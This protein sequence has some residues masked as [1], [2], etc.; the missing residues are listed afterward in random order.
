MH[1]HDAQERERL[2]RD[3]IARMKER[4][5]RTTDLA[6]EPVPV[7]KRPSRASLVV[8]A[9]AGLVVI[10]AA[11]I[12]G[13]IPRTR[14]DAT[15]VA[16]SRAANQQLL[17]VNTV[18]VKRAPEDIEI[19]LPASVQAVTEAPILARADGYL[20]RRL[21]DI[22]DHVA[23][24]QL[25]A[26]IEAPELELQVTQ[27]QAAQ[28]QS[29]AVEQQAAAALEQGRA[30]EQL[31][32]VTAQRWSNLFAKG[33]VSRQDT[34]VYQAQA[35]AQNANV[36][37]LER[38]LTAAKSNIAAA[39]ANLA[40]LHQLQS[41]RQVRAPFAGTITLRNVD[42]GALISA[43]TTLLFRVAQAGSL[44]TFVNV[45]QT[46]AGTVK[47]GLKARLTLAELPGQIFAGTVVRS[48]QALDANSRTLLT[49]IQLPNPNGRL[50]PGMYGTAVIEARRPGDRPLII[51][52]DTLM[53]RPQGPTVVE[54][55]SAGKAHYRRVTLG[56]DFGKTLEVLS[57]LAE[58]AQLV[59][60]PNDDV[61]EGLAVKA[62]PMK[63]EEGGAPGP[64]G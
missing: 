46:Y 48:S 38:S 17:T 19:E 9:V 26:E 7:G 57:G 35:Q 22:G 21:V 5:E 18:T 1:D 28:A 42:T 44:R 59:A 53:V 4:L 56:R 15:V 2:L 25:L 61:R 14:Q 29:E 23:A 40:R 64:R 63:N 47:P 20:K 30:N 41:Y 39:K 34:D 11:F 55:T 33:A 6:H 16:E 31:A 50:L 10:A 36:R 62:V 49:E 13:W 52:G 32:R 58:G 3:E 54:V 37:A 43:G 51:P 8:L 45:P 24:G 60:N 12:A 27:A